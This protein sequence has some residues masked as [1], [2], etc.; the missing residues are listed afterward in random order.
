MRHQRAMNAL[1]EMALHGKDLAAM[2]Q[3]YERVF[4]CTSRR[5]RYRL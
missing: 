1:G 3:F 4:L 5:S 2:Q